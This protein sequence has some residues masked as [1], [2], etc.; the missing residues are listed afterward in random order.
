MPQ[1]IF[2]KL[3]PAAVRRDPNETQLFKAEQAGEGEYAGTDA[4]VR[5]ILQNSMDAGTGNGP[6]RVRLALHPKA[7][8][9]EGKML[10]EYFARLESPLK[11]RDIAFDKSGIPALPNGF[12]VCEDFGT[13]GLGGDPLLSKDPIPGSSDRQDFFWFWRNIGRSGKTGDDLGRWGL[14]KTVYRA[15]SRVGCMMGLTVRESDQRQLLMGQSVLRIHELDGIEYVPEGYWCSDKDKSGLP[16]PIE[17]TDQLQWFRSQWK[18]SRKDEPGLS[19]VVP[20]VAEELTGLRLMQAVCIHFFMPILR[21]ELIVD[22]SAADIPLGNARLDANS[23]KSWC[24]SLK[25][26]GPKRSKRHVAPPVEFIKGCLRSN[27]TPRSTL[28][29]GETRMPEMTEAAFA[30]KDLQDLRESVEREQL[31]AVKVRI[32]LHRTAGKDVEGEMTVWLQ[33]QQPDLRCDTYYV[34]EGMTITKLNSKAGLKGIQAL[35]LVDKGPL[36]QLLGDSEGPAHEDWD[37]SEERPDRLWKK[38]KGRVTFCRKIVDFLL[39]VL[40][41]PTRKADFN[42]LSDFFSVEKI[43]SPQ[44]ARRPDDNGAKDPTFKGIVAKP[45]WFRLDPKRG[46]FRIVAN[47]SQ[48][49]PENAELTVSV[50]YDV[51]AGN[52]LKKWSSFDFDFKGKQE[53]IGFKGEYVKAQKI[54]GNVLKLT[55]FGP[56]FWFAAEG[57]DAHSDLF[58]RIEEAGESTVDS[59]EAES[60][61]TEA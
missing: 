56:K 48:P 2:A 28:L 15:A 25:W 12:M 23:L 7:D 33:R 18:L 13:R 59:S 40:A 11:H 39:E 1:W 41:P 37:T 47:A 38:W 55:S 4:L 26:D 50:A 6:V 49:I 22:L 60:E 46:G 54:S 29:L 51:P 19:V 34:R 16:I 42:L 8:L 30:P 3:D 58:V 14:G 53:R 45:R 10:T 20:Y 52:P 32:N 21:G 31:I 35:V 5:E 57:F 44:K 36:A 43:E 61:E 9:P 17:D 24:E 27:V